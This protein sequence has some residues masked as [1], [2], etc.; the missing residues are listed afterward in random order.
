MT[1]GER[2]AHHRAVGARPGSR[3]G[4]AARALPDQ[5]AAP[6]CRWSWAGWLRLRL[7]GPRLLLQ[8]AGQGGQPWPA[9]E[10]A[11]SSK[12]PREGSELAAA[13]RVRWNACHTG[14]WSSL[15][16]RGTHDPEVRGSNPL[17]P[18]QI[19]RR[20]PISQHQRH[21]QAPATSAEP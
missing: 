6:G 16:A 13:S 15:A 3:P 20:G 12:T 17:T 14:V 8:I 11:L 1:T 5:A 18:T 21:G 9:E 19:P 4:R 7:A 2:A 10:D